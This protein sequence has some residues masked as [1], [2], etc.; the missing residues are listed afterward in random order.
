MDKPLYRSMPKG[1]EIGSALGRG[2]FGVVFRAVRKADGLACVCKQIQVNGMQEKAR[3]EAEHEVKMLKRVSKGNKYIVQYIDNFIEGDSLHIIMELCEHGDL[4]QYLKA[5][6]GRPL[7]EQVVWKF[8][9]QIALGLSWLH[10][11]RVLHRD[12]KTLNVFLT[13]ADDAR[14]GDLGVARVLSH[15]TQFANTFVGTP[16]YLSPELCEEKPYNEKSDVW[17]YGCVI[18]E[19]CALRHPFEAKNHAALLIK[20]LRGQYAPVPRIYSDDLRSVIDDCM[21][22][23]MSRRPTITQLLRKASLGEWAGKLGL[24]LEDSTSPARP[25]EAASKKTASEPATKV[26]PRNGSQ[27]APESNVAQAQK[28][29]NTKVPVV[30]APPARRQSDPRQCAPAAGSGRQRVRSGA[31]RQI[32]EVAK[33]GQVI[34][35]PVSNNVPSQVIRNA[36]ARCRGSPTNASPMPQKKLSATAAKRAAEERRSE[37]AR[38]ADLPD[39]VWV[40]QPRRNVP[41]VQQLEQMLEN[42]SST[43]GE[44]ALSAAAERVLQETADQDPSNGTLLPSWLDEEVTA[45]ET[46]RL[47]DEEDEWISEETGDATIHPSSLDEEVAAVVDTSG[48]PPLPPRRS[49]PAAVPE[50]AIESS[51]PPF[52][53]VEDPED[54]AEQQ[55]SQLQGSLGGDLTCC[56]AFEDTGYEDSLAFTLEDTAALS[57]MVSTAIDRKSEG[58]DI[59]GSELDVDPSSTCASHLDA[60]SCSDF[61]GLHL[62]ANFDSD[63][64]LCDM[65]WKLSDT[66]ATTPEPEELFGPDQLD[67]PGDADE[68]DILEEEGGGTVSPAWRV[69]DAPESP[70]STTVKVQDVPTAPPSTTLKVVEEQTLQPEILPVVEPSLATP[71][72]RPVP[73]QCSTEAR[74]A[75]AERRLRGLTSQICRL[76]REVTKGLDAKGQANWDALCQLFR[77]KMQKDT[78]LTD[79]DQF[80]I[81]RY[82]FERLPV[83]S[84]NLLK[85]YKVL[86]LELERDRCLQCLAD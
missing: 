74:K 15:N 14:L 50:V 21:Q 66:T 13:A 3:K 59:L 61:D 80:E 49:A 79:E 26:Q 52:T 38:V 53:G 8:V 41:T 11:N 65:R 32:R 42:D 4:S 2:S 46:L 1:Y 70:P 76:H 24:S 71:T 64:L 55:S 57:D 51:N 78:D 35:A 37:I 33:G 10:A 86:H 43:S 6:G 23:D 84:A 19:M 75:R 31:K 77:S 17:A 54:P 22:R 85:V 28:G 29:A 39:L 9:I 56:S 36:P 72:Q 62:T 82:V 47:P 58:S 44:N 83:H 68:P 60:T 45:Q 27:A 7:V 12:I 73:V 48:R 5:Q 16:Y 18:Y 25:G 20:I 40:S 30:A 67:L 34:H 69:R 63:G 81:E